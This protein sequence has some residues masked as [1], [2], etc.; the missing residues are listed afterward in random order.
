MKRAVFNLKRESEN[1]KDV[2]GWGG[3]EPEHTLIFAYRSGGSDEAVANG[4]GITGK[5]V[6][7]AIG[8]CNIYFLSPIPVKESL[9]RLF[10]HIYIDLRRTMAWS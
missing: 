4:T 7:M 3:V 10:L 9:F 1:V 5:V 8:L 2:L 6:Q